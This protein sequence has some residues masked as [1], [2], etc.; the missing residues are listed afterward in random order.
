LYKNVITKPQKEKL[1]SLHEKQDL[2]EDEKHRRKLMLQ[3]LG[4]EFHLGF[5]LYNFINA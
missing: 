5:K 2:F 4:D 3:W 1:I